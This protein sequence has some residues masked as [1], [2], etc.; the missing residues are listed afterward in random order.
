[1]SLQGFPL[2]RKVRHKADFLKRSIPAVF[3]IFTN[4][5]F[6]MGGGV[7]NFRGAY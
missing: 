3:K 6:F 7:G 2:S 1:M 4:H 5:D